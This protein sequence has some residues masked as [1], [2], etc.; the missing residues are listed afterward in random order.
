MSEIEV[1][2][3]GVVSGVIATAALYLIGLL[4]RSH[5]I[6]WYQGVTYHGVDISGTWVYEVEI[7]TDDNV[8]F[9]M[10]ISQQAHVL[11]GDTTIM[12]GANLDNPTTITNLNISGGIWEGY[13]TLNMKSKDRT[14]LSYSTT[15]LRVL[16]G[17]ATLKGNY[18]YRSIRNEEIQ[19]EPMV[20]RRKK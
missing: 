13:V 6:P 19:S 14:K 8:K 17:G 4:F 7:N 18:I 5:L 15:L 3:F 10:T 11:A 9:E 16:N 2:V 20:W 1:I 12:Q